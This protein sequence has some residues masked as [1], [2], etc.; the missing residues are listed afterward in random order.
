M[1][2]GGL[3]FP[4][5]GA[6]LGIH[7]EAA[8]GLYRRTT[9]QSERVAGSDGARPDPGADGTAPLRPVR[10]ADAWRPRDGDPAVPAP[11]SDVALAGA[12]QLAHYPVAAACPNFDA[13]YG[14]PVLDT[15]RVIERITADLENRARI[16]VAIL[17]DTHGRNV[18]KGAFDWALRTIAEERADAGLHGGDS[19]DFNNQ[20]DAHSPT[21]YAS[22]ESELDG[23]ALTLRALEATGIPWLMVEANHDVRPNKQFA[24]RL[25]AHYLPWVANPITSLVERIPNIWTP[26]RPAM[27]GY[28]LKF[29]DTILAHVEAVPG[30]EQAAR[31]GY[32]AFT[33][34]GDDFGLDTTPIRGVFA[35]HPHKFRQSYLGRRAVLVDL[36]CLQNVP[37]YALTGPGVK[38]RDP[39]TQGITFA[40]FHYGR[41]DLDSITHRVYLP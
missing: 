13:L 3:S 36:D 28:W 29:G 11:R 35:G 39:A 10:E 31:K 2:D 41:L 19:F 23:G 32:N 17:S 1:R 25:P 15:K 38:Y 33:N 27:Q 24:N 26:S 5:I 40:T 9:T 14:R 34:R 8:R 20:S 18:D 37:G 7:P 12:P 21:E 6:R 4:E 16:R 22:W 30:V